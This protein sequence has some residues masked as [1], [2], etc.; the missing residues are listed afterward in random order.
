MLYFHY[1][2]DIALL[3]AMFEILKS[4][5]FEI[6]SSNVLWQFKYYFKHKITI[7]QTSIVL[8]ENNLEGNLCLI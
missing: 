6:N 8:V 2:I 7:I 5:N 3:T 4:F 1:I